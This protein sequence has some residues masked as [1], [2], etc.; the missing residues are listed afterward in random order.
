M[1]KFSLT[2]AVR[3]LK[4][5]QKQKWSWGTISKW[6]PWQQATSLTE[7]VIFVVTNETRWHNCM[8]KYPVSCSFLACLWSEKSG[9]HISNISSR[10]PQKWWVLCTC[11]APD[12]QHQIWLRLKIQ[13]L[14]E[15]DTKRQLAAFQELGNYDLCYIV[16]P[17]VCFVWNVSVSDAETYFMST[18]EFQCSV[19]V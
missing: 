7:G 12:I 2:L 19:W 18:S 5:K 9:P 10:L 15:L 6:F 8:N 4:D 3:C 13:I 14:Y 17:C 11:D 1:L 16:C